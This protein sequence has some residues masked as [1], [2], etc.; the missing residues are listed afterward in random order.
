MH[1]LPNL[2]VSEVISYTRYDHST[3]PSFVLLYVRCSFLP[4]SFNPSLLAIDRQ[5]RMKEG[6][7]VDVAAASEI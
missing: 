4:S 2:N 1:G 3:W 5:G 6:S 7:D